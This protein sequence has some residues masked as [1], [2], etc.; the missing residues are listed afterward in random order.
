M[1][2]DADRADAEIAQATA[3][4]IK[5]TRQP[6]MRPLGACYWCG[7]T[8]P[9]QGLFCGPDCRDDWQRERDARARDGR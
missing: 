7:D 2:D 3:E 1:A 8:S 5:R 9:P 4:A 6:A